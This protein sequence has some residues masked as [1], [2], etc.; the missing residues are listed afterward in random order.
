VSRVE[1]KLYEIADRYRDALSRLADPDLPAEAVDA[2]LEGL[3][4]ELSLKAWNVAAVLLQMEGEAEL[5]RR[6]EE[7]MS[8][9]RRALERRAAGL[10]HYLKTQMERIEVYEIRSPH[11]VIKVKPNPPRV[12]V[13]DEER[14]PGRFKYT[15]TVVHID[16]TAIRD[17]IL[18]GEEVGGA[19]LEQDTHVEIG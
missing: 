13:D 7:R 3:T 5:I 19:R 9:R 16:K 1:M 17:A 10:R 4:G 15:E 8:R 12:I 2:T 6:A 18:S 11:F 14:L